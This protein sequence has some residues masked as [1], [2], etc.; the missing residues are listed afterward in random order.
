M[1]T[2][3]KIEIPDGAKKE[4][5]LLY[6]HDIVSLVDN[7]NIPDS[8]ILNLDQMKLKYVPCAN[9]T[10][11]KKGS[12]SIGIAGSDGK[13]CI[14]GTLT[15]S[16]K[17]GFLPLQLIYGGKTNQSLPCFK[18]PESFSLSLN[19]KH[20]SNTL[21]SIK[22]RDKVIIPHVSAQHETLSNPNQAALLIFDVFR[23]QITDEVTSHLLQ[24]NIYFVT[25]PNNMTHLFQPLDF[26]SQWT[27]QKKSW[28]TSL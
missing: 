7:H 24:K 5:Q 2:T 19:L 13:W 17:G 6:L 18:F 9:H 4:I 26:N 10:L 8:L 22:I 12:N 1:K 21:E 14:T 15:V 23:S 27:L 16:L 3:G 25:V 20:Y 11:T 28:K